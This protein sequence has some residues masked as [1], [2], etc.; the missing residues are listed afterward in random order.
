ML[1][2]GC[3]KIILIKCYHGAFTS[4]RLRGRVMNMQLCA[5]LC[6]FLTDQRKTS[7]IEWRLL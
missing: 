4:G 3:Q 1:D 5:D 7:T 6:T 2:S